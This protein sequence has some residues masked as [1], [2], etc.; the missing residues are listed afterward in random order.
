MVRRLIG[1]LMLLIGLLGVALSVAGV[2]VGRQIVD[3]VGANLESNLLLTSQSLDTMEESLVLAKTTVSEVS[4]GLDTMEDT[5]V[6]LGQTI[7]ETRPLL[8]QVNQITTEDLPQSVESVQDAMPEMVAVAAAIDDTLTILNNFRIDEEIFGFSIQYDLGIDYDPVVPF[9]ESV[10]QIGDS[11]DGLPGSL[12]Q[13][14]TNLD[15]ADENL[16][17]IAVDVIA[18]SEDLETINGRVAEIEPLLDDFITIV[19]EAN[20]RTRESRA[21]IGEQLE[22]VKLIVTGLMVWLGL[23]QIAPLYLGWELA[24]GRR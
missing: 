4:A 21:R 1:I 15:V 10:A 6:Q 13:L 7:T 2:V 5:A 16:E 14:E 12:R 22:M 17:M 24:T 23:T 8:L 18:I 19:I 20:D 9:D 3:D 11:L